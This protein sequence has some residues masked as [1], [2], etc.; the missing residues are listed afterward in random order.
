M[1]CKEIFY[2]EA[3]QHA[4][5][6]SVRILQIQSA[7]QRITLFSKTHVDVKNVSVCLVI[8][9][10]LKIEELLLVSLN[11]AIQIITFNFTAINLQLKMKFEFFV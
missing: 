1:K 6:K 2:R 4:I 10:V 3:K 11:N 7:L 5:Y 9:K 8:F